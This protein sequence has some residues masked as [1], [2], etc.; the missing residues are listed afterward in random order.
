M[1]REHLAANRHWPP[2]I[3]LAQLPELVLQDGPPS[4]PKL[5]DLFPTVISMF[6]LCIPDDFPGEFFMPLRGATFDEN[7]TPSDFWCFVTFLESSGYFQRNHSC[8]W[9]GTTI[10]ETSRNLPPAKGT[11]RFSGRG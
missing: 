6:E 10:D 7:L 8:R 11:P 9:A 2:Q 3:S 5:M 1:H 4:A